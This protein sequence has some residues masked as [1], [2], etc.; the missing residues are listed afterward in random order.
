MAFIIQPSTTFLFLS[1]P[2]CLL[3]TS[4]KS[5]SNISQRKRFFFILNYVTSLMSSGSRIRHQTRNKSNNC[6]AKIFM[7]FFSTLSRI[8]RK[9][10]RPNT[11]SSSLLFFFP[12]SY[13]QCAKQYF[14]SFTLLVLLHGTT[15]KSTSLS[16]LT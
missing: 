7:F 6:W 2:L 16:F 5:T 8:G 15:M 13:F 3:F 1:Q 4:K 11:V 10:A 9:T 12:S 14:S